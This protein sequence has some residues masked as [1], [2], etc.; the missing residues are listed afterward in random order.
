MNDSPNGLSQFRKI[1]AIPTDY[2]RECVDFDFEPFWVNLELGQ[3]AAGSKEKEMDL[4]QWEGK[5][6]CVNSANSCGDPFI[7]GRVRELFQ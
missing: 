5:R 6:P 4:M 2:R 7:K 3:S 1:R